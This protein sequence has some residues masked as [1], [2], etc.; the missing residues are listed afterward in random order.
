MTRLLFVAS[1]AYPL[2]KTGGLADIAGSLPEVLRQQGVDVRL[3]LPA[4]RQLLDGIDQSRT[5][6]E[7]EL[8]GISLRILATV[9]PGTGVETWLLDHPSFAERLGNPYHGPDGQPW[10]DNADRFMLLSRLA[11]AISTGEAGLDWRPD[12]LHCN[13]WHTGPA[14][15]LTHLQEQRPLTLFT[16]HSLAHMGLFDRGTF[17]RLQLPG[18][19]WQD[20]AL[21]FYDQFSFIKGG[22]VYADYITTVSPTYAREICESPG[23]MGLEGLLQARR[24]RLVGILNG[25]DHGVWNPAADPYLE[26]HYDAANLEGKALEKTALQRSLGLAEL[27]DRPLL[28]IVGRLVEQKGLELILPALGDILAKPA[29]VVVLGTGE[30]RYEEQLQ[31]VARAHPDAMAVILAYDESLAHRIEASADI[32]LMP[33]LFEPCG[34]NQLY[35]LR[36]GTLPLVRA[37]G[38]LAD[39]VVDATPQALADGTATG[40]VFGPPDSGEFMSALARAIALW[41]DQASWRRLQATAM[42]QDFSWQRSAARYLE[43]YDSPR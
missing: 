10:P 37:V 22:L 32:F 30:R 16:V 12:V 14:V 29:Q 1:E 28:G 15:A 41:R 42:A 24:E 27:D 33:S 36:Y 35:S 21:E 11:A 34:L 25:I 26:H 7:L 38:G 18:H 4:Y 6:A 23:G 3:L 9:L 31:A 19:F 13:D 43:L 20:S 2:I 5:V 17:E 39:T 8:A 40:F